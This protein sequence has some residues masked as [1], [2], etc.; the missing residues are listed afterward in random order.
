MIRPVA[1]GNDKKRV[2]AESPVQRNEAE[3]A[4][5]EMLA[6]ADPALESSLDLLSVSEEHYFAAVH[7]ESSGLPTAISSSAEV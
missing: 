6:A 5:E 1:G 7:Q 4:L 2:D 3:D